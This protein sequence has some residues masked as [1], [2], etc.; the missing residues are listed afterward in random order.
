LL[1]QLV[2]P[3]TSFRDRAEMPPNLSLQRTIILPT[4]VLA[5]TLAMAAGLD[6]RPAEV[7]DYVVVYAALLGCPEFP[8]IIA[9]SKIGADGAIELPG[10]A[11]I[12]VVHLTQPRIQSEP[13]RRIAKQRPYRDTPH[14]LV[15]E[16]LTAN[17]YFTAKE[18][19]LASLRFLLED[20]CNRPSSK[21]RKIW[22]DR[23]QRDLEQI[24][25]LKRLERG[26]TAGRPPDMRMQPTNQSV[27]HF[28]CA[29]WSPLCL[30]ADA[31]CWAP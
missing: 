19:Y 15:V 24:E 11:R 30:A 25:R 26:Q 8:G 22:R 27:T 9:V 21:P 7:G 29:N 20:G 16:V 5:A 23:W 18:Q 6:D 2:R 31:G 13:S 3:G 1:S 17:E 12:E 14:S 28:A 4:A 10:L